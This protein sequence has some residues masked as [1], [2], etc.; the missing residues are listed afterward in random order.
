M[1]TTFE[2]VIQHN[3]DVHRGYAQQAAL[4]AFD[5]L[6]RLE[7]ELSRFVENSDISRINNLAEGESACVGL[8]AFRCLELAA[9]MNEQT[10]GAFDVNIGLL[11]GCWLAE[12]GSV[13]RPSKQPRCLSGAREQ[14]AAG[15][16]ELNEDDH[17]VQVFKAPL[18]IDLGGIGKGYAV[19]RMAEMLRQWGFGAA[20]INGG[21]SSVLA[22]DA[23]GRMRGWPVQLGGVEDHHPEL[24]TCLSLTERAV[25]GSSIRNRRH[26]IDPRRAEPVEGTLSAWAVAAD[27]A[28]SDALATAFMVMT[29]EQVD[30]YCSDHPNVAAM[31]LMADATVD[32]ARLLRC[33]KH[34]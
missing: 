33:L 4:A 30:C 28:T 17:S 1:A 18:Q 11:L 9:K 20:L 14:V 19:D 13:Q 12:D 22:L 3:P 23:P 34:V 25:G 5:E 7:A 2:V 29:P 6:D 31:V 16:L 10:G 15:R 24:P 32:S 27:A 26:I 21:F 8:D